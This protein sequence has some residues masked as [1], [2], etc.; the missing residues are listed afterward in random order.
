MLLLRMFLRSDQP[1]EDGRIHRYFSIVE[2]RRLPGEKT[3]QRTLMYLGEINDQQSSWRKTLDVF[4][5]NERCYTR[6]VCLPKTGEFPP[7]R[8]TACR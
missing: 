5:V 4:D 3:V 7:T 6:M 8:W 2:D 1:Q